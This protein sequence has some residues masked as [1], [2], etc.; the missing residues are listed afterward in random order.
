M[1]VRIG[2]IAIDCHNAKLVADFWSEALGYRITEVDDTGV[3]VAGDSLVPTLAVPAKQA[4]HWHMKNR[5]CQA[6]QPRRRI[7]IVWRP[8]LTHPLVGA[9]ERAEICPSL[10]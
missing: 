1:T 9:R 7:W 2:D 4:A 5:G 6:S 10:L 3:V 8:T